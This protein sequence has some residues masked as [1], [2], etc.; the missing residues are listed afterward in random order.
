MGGNVVVSVFSTN[1]SQ[2]DPQWPAHFRTSRSGPRQEGDRGGH[3]GWGWNGT[4]AHSSGFQN[5]GKAF[6]NL[7]RECRGISRNQ[8]LQLGVFG[9][10]LLQDGDV[11]IGVF[12]EG[13]QAL[14]RGLGV[15]CLPGP[16]LWSA[17]R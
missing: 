7:S 8:S 3:G 2:E 16:P 17:R 9:F 15:C 1:L 5:S 6:W 12:P 14:V 10:G 13:E 4:S 11:G